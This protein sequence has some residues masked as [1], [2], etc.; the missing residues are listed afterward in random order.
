MLALKY[1]QMSDRLISSSQSAFLPGRFILDGVVTLHES[2]HELNG[3]NKDVV[4]LKLNFEK[5]YDKIKWPF[6]QQ[7]LRIKGFSPMWC[8]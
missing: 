1:L 8:Q 6:L 7:S 3:N 2:L 5:V 4:I